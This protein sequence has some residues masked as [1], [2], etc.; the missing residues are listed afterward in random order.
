MTETIRG[1]NSQPKQ[2]R[3]KRGLNLN[4]SARRKKRN[5][6]TLQRQITPW[7]VITFILNNCC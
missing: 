2:Q 6:L 3:K 5:K 1:K 4:A 7:G